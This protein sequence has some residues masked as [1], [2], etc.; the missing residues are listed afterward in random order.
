MADENAG[1]LRQRTVG[2]G[3]KEDVQFVHQAELEHEK[4]KEE[5]VWG[6]TP[7]GQGAFFPIFCALY[8]Y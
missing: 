4:E 6:K 5:I 3:V 1:G 8:I 7:S 2:N